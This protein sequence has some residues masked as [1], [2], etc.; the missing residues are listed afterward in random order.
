VTAILVVDDLLVRRGPRR[1]LDGLAVQVA[2]GEVIGV[3]GPNGAGKSTLLAVIAGV[4]AR[5][6]GRVDVDGHTAGSIEARRR[7]GYV[8][9]AAD[10]PGHLTCDEVIALVSAVKHA[11]LD[12]ADHD[13]LG[14]A[15]LAGQRI[16][17]MS[18][19]QRRRT[20]LGAALVGAPRLLVLDEPSNGLD[21]GG[22]DVLVRLVGSRIAAGA[23]AIIASHDAELLDRLGARR[24]PL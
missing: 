17:R 9:E 16:D 12:G 7:I 13:A 5:T 22:V 20:C 19:G 1:L 2:G 15:D 6:R 18:L 4:L 11:R 3:T 24:L 8:P 14:L 10:P 21:P 23:G